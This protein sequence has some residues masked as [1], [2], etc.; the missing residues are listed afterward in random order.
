[1]NFFLKLL[2]Y[3]IL[4]LNLQNLSY[5]ENGVKFVNIDLLVNETKIGN[6]MLDKIRSLDQENIKELKS[7]EKEI[8]D[9]QD[10]IKLKKNLISELELEKEVNNLNMKISNFNNQKKIMINNLADIKK[11]ELNLFFKN[12]NPVVQKY[13][14]ENS[15]DIIIN[16]KNIF[17]GN[18]NSDITND[19]IE[20]ININFKNE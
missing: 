7:F 18:K 20:K 16:N 6:Q 10:G 8:K 19:L 11:K 9:T 13:M 2:F 17:M 5:A 12:I 14:S 4:F 3:L 1:M 15:I